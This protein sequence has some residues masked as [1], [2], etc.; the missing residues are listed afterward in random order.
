MIAINPTVVQALA[1]SG[2]LRV[3]INTGNPV[4]ARAAAD[5]G[6]PTGVS[7]DLARL[8]GERLGLP[9]R[10]V[11]FAAAQGVNEALDADGW[12]VAFMASDPERAVRVAFSAPYVEIEASYMVRA[13][14]PFRSCADLDRP[15]LRIAT[16]NRAAYDLHLT[17]TLRHAA[18]ER[19]P[20]Q[21]AALRL[22]VDGGLDAGAGLRQAL[23]AFA[24][25]RPGMR[26]LPD[27]FM[28][29]EQCMAVPRTCGV[30]AATTVEAFVDDL[31]RSGAPRRL[32]DCNGQHG[33]PIPDG[34]SIPPVPC[35]ELP[36]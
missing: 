15:G 30:E 25:D 16:G 3:A 21:G 13:E 8:F 18:I 1:P 26:V 31:K 6:P 29:I 22:F 27:R 2:T 4:L 5:G 34:T 35:G 28:A 9:T 7:V 32:L 23:D 17:R 33:S 12:D 36:T 24:R 20:D 14:A 11:A 19:A 10:L